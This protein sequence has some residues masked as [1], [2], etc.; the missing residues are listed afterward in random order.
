MI[1]SEHVELYPVCLCLS[2]QT[3]FKVKKKKKKEFPSVIT[4]FLLEQDD[5]EKVLASQIPPYLASR[6]FKVKCAVY[7]KHSVV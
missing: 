6:L 7:F 1:S 2:L 5:L 4:V 3:D